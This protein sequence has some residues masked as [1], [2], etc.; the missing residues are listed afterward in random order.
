MNFQG[1]IKSDQKMLAEML[2]PG[3]QI[4]LLVVKPLQPDLGLPF[5]GYVAGGAEDDHEGTLI[6][7]AV[8]R[9]VRHETHACGMVRLWHD[10]ASQ[11]EPYGK[12][13]DSGRFNP[14]YR[15]LTHKHWLMMP[16]GSSASSCPLAQGLKR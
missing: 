8:E 1:V 7:D 4:R 14:L 5:H 15:R 13:I 10:V 2:P 3:M 12:G 16:Y 11:V 9:V 6:E